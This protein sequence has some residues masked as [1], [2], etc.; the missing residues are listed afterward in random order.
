MAEGKWRHASE[1]EATPHYYRAAE[2][3]VTKKTPL[4]LNNAARWPSGIG[5]RAGLASSRALK[6]RRSR[7]GPGHD[8]FPLMRTGVKHARL[9]PA[10]RRTV[11]VCGS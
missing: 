11:L 9:G 4:R 6:K 3:A 1:H 5:E 10:D 8:L 2:Q 7:Y